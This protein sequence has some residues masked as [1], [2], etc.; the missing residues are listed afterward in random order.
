MSEF[1]NNNNQNDD[2]FTHSQDVPTY[3]TADLDTPPVTQE[4]K[5]QKKGHSTAVVIISCVLAAIIGA[6]SSVAIFHA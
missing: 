2:F 3:T 6:A 4:I 5:P 1:Q